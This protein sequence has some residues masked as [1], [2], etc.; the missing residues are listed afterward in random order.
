M[1]FQGFVYRE[2]TNPKQKYIKMK[3]VDSK[4]NATV[5]VEESMKNMGT[6][7]SP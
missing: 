3:A 1:H 7:Q 2:L 5:H 6:L 4:E